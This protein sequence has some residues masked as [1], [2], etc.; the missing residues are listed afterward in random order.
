MR[1]SADSRVL[2]VGVWNNSECRQYSSS[3]RSVEQELVQKV[4]C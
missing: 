3:G 4:Q 2:V 1:V